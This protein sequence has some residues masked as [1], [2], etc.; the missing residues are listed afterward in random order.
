M[1][2]HKPPGVWRC[3]HKGRVSVR[4]RGPG[5]PGSDRQ[6][7]SGGGASCPATLLL[8]TIVSQAFLSFFQKEYLSTSQ[9]KSESVEKKTKTSKTGV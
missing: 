1:G 5:W 8:H 6:E 2:F 7:A 9:I 3:T 4:W